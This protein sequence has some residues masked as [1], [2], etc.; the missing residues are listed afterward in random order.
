MQVLDKCPYLT[1]ILIITSVFIYF[2]LFCSFHSIL[3]EIYNN[4]YGFSFV[5][6]GIR[7]KKNNGDPSLFLL[8]DLKIFMKV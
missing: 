7:K 6:I 1:L 2:L 4:K 5:F 3:K 8:I